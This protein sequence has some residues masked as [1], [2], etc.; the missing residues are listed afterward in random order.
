[1]K[2][3]KFRVWNNKTKSW[4]HGP[5]EEVNLFGEMILLGGFMNGIS[6]EDLNEC[7]AFQYSGCK[8]KNDREIYE[9]ESIKYKGQTGHV[10]FFA[11]SFRVDWGD[12]TDSELG[13]LLIDD[14]EV[15]E[16][17]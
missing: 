3:I 14:M 10:V 13:D 7:L 6:V 11:G 2:D 15:I 17:R 8:D 12:Q 5:G 16:S 1:M 9:G 4:V